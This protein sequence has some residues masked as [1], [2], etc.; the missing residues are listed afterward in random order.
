MVFLK[1]LVFTASLLILPVSGFLIILYIA[2]DLVRYQQEKDE[3][4]AGT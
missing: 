2:I 1:A 3:R 4:G